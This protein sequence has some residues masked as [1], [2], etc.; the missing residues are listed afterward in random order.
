[1]EIRRRTFVESELRASSQDLQSKVDER[2]AEI[3]KYSNE[4]HAEATLRQEA[5][6]QL[7]LSLDLARVAVWT[8]FALEDR[9]VWS[10][11]VEEVLGFKAEQMSD[12]KSMRHLILPEDRVATDRLIEQSVKNRQQFQA[13]FR[14]V[15]PDGNIRWISGHG[16]VICDAS[17]QVIR[18]SGVN[19]DISE[20]KKVEQQLETSERHFRELAESLPQIVWTANA[21]G[22]MEYQNHRWSLVTGLPMGKVSA[23]DRW[24]LVHPDDVQQT[25]ETRTAAI[26]AGSEYDMEFRLFDASKQEYRWQW[27][28]AIPIRDAQGALVRWFGTST[29]IHERKIAE[30]RLAESEQRL[31][32]RER[33]LEILF[34]N[35]SA[36]DYIWDFATSEVTAHPAIWALFGEPN[37]RGS[38]PA[39]WFIGRY[40]PDDMPEMT[41]QLQEAMDGT[42][43]FDVEHRVVWPDGT[44]RWLASRG[45]HVRD[46][47]GKPT[48]IHGLG[49]DIT[50]R[51]LAALQIQESERQF[52]ELADAMP[53]IV[54]RSFAS[55]EVDYC[56]ARWYQYSG[57]SIEESKAAGWE[58]VMHP[59]D[60]PKCRETAMRGFASGQPFDIEFRLRR[61]SDGEYRWHLARSVPSRDS[62]GNLLRWFGA[63]TDIHE[64]KLAKEQLVRSLAEKN[65][66]F[67]EMHH[68]VKNN[69]QVISSLL[70]MQSELLKDQ[71]AAAVLKE[72]HQRVLSMALIHEQLYSNE[73]VSQINFTDF[74][75][76]LVN[77]LFQSYSADK[78]RVTCRLDTSPVH[79]LIDQA[80]PLGL[81]LNEL[82]TNAFKYAYPA[83]TTGEVVI[84]LHATPKRRVILTV[85]DEG[86]G[87]PDK[88]DWS[89]SKSMGLPIVELLTQQL[90]G[91]LTIR[92][93]PGAA[94]TVEFPL[95]TEKASVATV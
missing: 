90:G 66:L 27:V 84:S 71:S 62:Q 81:I 86:V 73:A 5:A 75:E 3:R 25:S 76:R 52:R 82:V 23:Q 8:W 63:A 32:A 51:K 9:T 92:T 83:E 44:V 77:E 11:A 47:D 74:T 26:R 22:E 28:H 48:K 54:W 56:N 65:I 50:D 17:G 55:G 72:S 13:E 87:L 46:Q 93:K 37:G 35:G 4:L 59:E 89:G 60:L 12:Y 45:F 79:L 88:F 41:R 18:V 85:S 64:Q 30:L 38:A 21:S 95:E 61:A 40:H 7:R 58:D 15:L 42:H 78:G 68:R 6:D 20:K 10:G 29:D 69:L 57:V 19:I 33:Q 24:K 1:M 14:I 80:I 39:A 94:F 49:F 43:A 91:T 34:S 53:Q 2:T 36:G 67:K 31:R 70:R 16:D